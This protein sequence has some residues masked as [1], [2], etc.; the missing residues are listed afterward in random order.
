M[1][2]CTCGVDV[3][4]NEHTTACPASLYQAGIQRGR[5]EERNASVRFLRHWAALSSA[6]RDLEGRDTL[7]QFAKRLEDGEQWLPPG[8]TEPRD[9]SHDN[10]R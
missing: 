7:Y 9:P 5:A 1:A 2:G 6:F 3:P 10:P 4:I 8:R